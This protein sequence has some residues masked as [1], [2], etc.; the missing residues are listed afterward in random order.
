MGHSYSTDDLMYMSS[1][2][3]QDKI[4]TRFRSSFQYI[5][6]KD[7]NTIRL[8]YNLEPD[9]TNTSLNEINSEGLIY[10][11]IV[12][13][14]SEEIGSQ[15]LKEAE[16]Y[17]KNAPDLPGGYIDLAVAYAQLG[18]LRKATENLGTALQLAKTEQDKYVIYYNYAVVYLNNNNPE[19]A[20][21]YAQTAQQINNNDEILDLISNIQH[22]ISTKKKPFKDNFLTE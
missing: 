19:S 8:L 7:L 20:L 14:S 17:I 21:K 2:E 12:L 3:T 1:R 9:I 16:N 22:A 18:K 4:F 6:A 15:K 11:P 13:G 10:P 5:S